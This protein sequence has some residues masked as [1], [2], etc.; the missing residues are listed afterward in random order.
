MQTNFSAAVIRV[1][2]REI[3]Y[4]P[5]CSVS[6]GGSLLS[7]LTTYSSYQFYHRT[8]SGTVVGVNCAMW[9]QECHRA[10]FDPIIFPHVH[11]GAF[12]HSGE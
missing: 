2:N 11:L 4:T 5:H 3:R 7:V 8:F 12:F 1:K 9:C 6:N 10:V